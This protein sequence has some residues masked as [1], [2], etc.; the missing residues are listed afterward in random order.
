MDESQVIDALSALS[1][2]T[3]LRMLRYLVKAGEK[4][5]PA[6]EVAAAVNSS[7][8]RNSFHLTALT[9]AG[10]ITAERQSRQ[11]IYRVDFANVGAM[12]GYLVQDCCAGH[13]QVLQCCQP[14]AACCG[15]SDDKPL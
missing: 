3:R 7:S 1:Q 9:R 6:G 10:L 15:T 5:A 12:I 13:A 2:E 14:D 8:S 11:I 4:G